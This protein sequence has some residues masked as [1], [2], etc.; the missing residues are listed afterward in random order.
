MNRTIEFYFN[1]SFKLND[2]LMIL[3]IPSLYCSITLTSSVFD[4]LSK[5]IILDMIGLKVCITYGFPLL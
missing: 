2:E 4:L 5:K 1:C 3:I